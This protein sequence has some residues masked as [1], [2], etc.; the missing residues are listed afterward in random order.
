VDPA[1]LGGV[2]GDD[3]GERVRRIHK[4]V[5][6]LGREIRREPAGAAEAADADAARQVGAIG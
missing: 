6:A 1:C 3:G 2:A 5:D 4:Q